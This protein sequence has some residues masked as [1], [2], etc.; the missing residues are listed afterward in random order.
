MQCSSLSS[1]SSAGLFS[2]PKELLT[3]N[4]PLFT[5]SK[6][7]YRVSLF[8][9]ST[10]SKLGALP[11]SQ[12]PPEMRFTPYA[13]KCLSYLPSWISSGISYIIFSSKTVHLGLQHPALREALKTPDL[14]FLQE[15]SGG[16][17]HLSLGQ[18]PFCPLLHIHKKVQAP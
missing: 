13:Q 4:P 17:S 9:C 14:T 11:R 5:S 3:T 12:T 16:S 15:G 18:I 10:R 1:F 7:C 8:A 6:H 2:C